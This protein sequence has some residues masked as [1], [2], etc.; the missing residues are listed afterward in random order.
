MQSLKSWLIFLSL[1]LFLAS[2]FLFAG[3]TGK[4]AGQIRDNENRQ[5]IIGANILVKGTTLG[6]AADEKG[7]YFVLLVPPGTY[8]L[9]ISMIGYQTIIV[10]NVKVQVDLTTTI[11]ALL[12]STAIQIEEVRV[13]AENKLVQ[14]DVT[15]TRR[16]VTQ[17]NIRVTPGLESVTDIFKTQAGANL[18]SVPQNIKLADGSQVQVRDESVKDINVRGGRGGEI[19]YV[20]DGMPVTHPVYGGRSVVDLNV[21]DVQSVELITGAFNA[22]YGQAQSGVVNINTRSGSDNFKGGIEYKTDRWKALGES[23]LTDYATAYFSGPEPITRALFPALGFEIPGKMDFFLSTN[24]NL[25]N[26]PYNNQRDRKNLKLF[27]LNVTE[28]Q[29]NSVNINA[30]VNWDIS[31]ENKLTFGYHNT[32]LQWSS[33][34]WLWKFYP[35]RIPNYYRNNTTGSIRYNQVISK[36]SYFTI[37][38]GY[39]GVIYKGSLNG[40]TPAD[41]WVKDSSGK[42]ISTITSP[43]IDPRT[44]FFNEQGSGNIWRDDKT[45]SFTLK[46]D[47]TSQINSA[48]LIKTGLELQL[49]NISYIDIQD[50]GVKLSRYGLGLDSLPPPGSFPLFGQFRSVFNVKPI[51]GS[52]FIQDKL[53]LEFLIINAGLRVDGLMLGQTVMNSDWKRK[54]EDA[55][56]LKADW[57]QYIYRFSPRFGISFPISEDMV[58]FFSY[59]HFNQLP[60]LQYYYRDPYSGGTTGNPKLD[61]EQT[62]LYEFGLTKQITDYWAIDAKSYAK[63]IS[64]QVGTTRLLAALGTPVDLFDNNGYARAR[65]L[66]FEINKSY[67]DFTSGR[68]TYTIQWAS[69]Y[70]SSA[71]DD[72]IRSQTDFPYPIRER[73]L[74]WDVRQQLIF[75]GMLSVQKNQDVKLFGL[76]LPDDWNLTVFY[77]YSTGTPYTPGQATTDPA[78]QQRKENTVIGPSYSSTDLKFEKGF[79]LGGIRLAFFAEVYNLFDQH[80]I[81]MSYG[82]NTWTGKPYRYGDVQNPQKNFYDYYTMQSI[83]DPRQFSTGRTTKLGIKIDF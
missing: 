43:Q 16:Q 74:A 65:G 10:Q 20:I 67:S 29:D 76:K 63:D 44:G 27:G 53:E 11:N 4:I 62:I 82:F 18:S 34:D 73:A 80:N 49:N 28:R 36:S 12:S 56:G 41:F 60:E 68:F 52:A 64:G 31:A 50:G 3:N 69:G 7:Y 19:L 46:G 8:E 33:F 81:Q 6:A 71:F 59:G 30:K 5:P 1:V 15:S 72:Y 22:E 70:S 2:S 39:L 78:E 23:Y 48:H 9:Q 77:R 25:S 57:K 79:M 21:T 55:T 38:L 61:Y 83:L 66:E 13:T 17:E 26:T 14:K 58:I 32:Y 42:L 54:W 40:K 24:F 47:F 75:Q 45:S 37:N 35:D 51:I